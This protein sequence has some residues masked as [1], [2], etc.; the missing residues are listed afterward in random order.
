VPTEFAQELK[1]RRFRNGGRLDQLR[2]VVL[3]VSD[4]L[5]DRPQAQNVLRRCMKDRRRITLGLTQPERPILPLDDH[6][7]PVLNS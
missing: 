3:D 4:R 5:A 7:H 6:R 2:P 1:K